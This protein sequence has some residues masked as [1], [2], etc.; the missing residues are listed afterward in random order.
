MIPWLFN[1]PVDAKTS[2]ANHF[3]KFYGLAMVVLKLPAM[4]SAKCLAYIGYIG[5][6]VNYNLEIMSNLCQLSHWSPYGIGYQP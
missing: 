6:G 3:F 5:V 1:Q 4:E 2:T